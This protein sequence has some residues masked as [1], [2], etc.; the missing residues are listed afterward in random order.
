MKRHSVK[1]ILRVV[2]GSEFS[3]LEET[4]SSNNDELTTIV[5]EDK[6]V[7]NDGAIRL[8]LSV[9]CNDKVSF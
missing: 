1:V 3:A 4:S 8:T 6:E 5:F 9:P 7:E 2:P